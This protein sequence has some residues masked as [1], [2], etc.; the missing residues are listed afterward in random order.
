VEKVLNQKEQWIRD[1]DK[2][3][4]VKERK[5]LKK[6]AARYLMTN[7]GARCEMFCPGCAICEAYRCA[8]ILFDDMTDTDW[9]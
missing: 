2:K 8:D 4:S 1:N 3:L 9:W 5:V 7:W 6:L